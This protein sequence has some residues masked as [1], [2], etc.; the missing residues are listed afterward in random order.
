VKSI[1]IRYVL[2]WFAVCAIGTVCAGY[3]TVR[4]QDP[5]PDPSPT[6]AGTTAQPEPSPVEYFVRDVPHWPEIRKSTFTLRVAIGFLLDYSVFSQDLTNIKQVGKQLNGWNVRDARLLLFGTFGKKYKVGY[7]FAATYKGFDANPN[8]LWDILDAYLTF[9]LPDKRTNV[10]VGK[11]KQTFDM[12]MVGDAASFPQQ[13]RLLSPF[14]VN[15]DL[16]IKAIHFTK[17]RRMT[18]AAGIFNGKLLRDNTAQH[19]GTDFTARVTGLPWDKQEDNRFLHLGIAYRYASPDDGTLRYKGRPE[20]N[21]GPYYFDTGNI[22]AKHANHI[23]LEFLLN[24]K[25]VSVLGEYNHAWVDSPTLGNPQFEAFYVESSW[26][27]TGETRP[28]D[29]T[30]GYPRRI[31]PKHSWGSWEVVSR[32]GRVDDRFLQSGSFAKTYL[33][34]NWWASRQWK[35]GIGWGH[36]WLERSDM[37]GSTNSVLSRMQWVY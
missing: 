15:R 1:L 36:T 7:F 13:E 33:G 26:I 20:T 16:G 27:I 30:V 11:M 14:F 18:M 19:A 12:E 28:Y 9:P 31:I 24:V 6:P 32:I 4:A 3:S 25:N 22:P 8:R 5:D 2:I 35:F 10:M 23:G 29:P 34:V 37:N 17:N 21:V